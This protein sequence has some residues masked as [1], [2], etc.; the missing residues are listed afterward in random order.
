MEN[1]EYTI[2]KLKY[3]FPIKYKAHFDIQYEYTTEEIEMVVMYNGY[4]MS[5]KDGDE[6][7]FRRCNNRIRQ[8]LMDSGKSGKNNIKIKQHYVNGKPYSVEVIVMA[9]QIHKKN[10]K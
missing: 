4:S 10:R 9:K 1:V 8:A 5:L 3:S 6:T 2:E 7:V